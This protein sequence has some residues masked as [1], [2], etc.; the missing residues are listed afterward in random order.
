MPREKSMDVRKIVSM[1]DA[2]VERIKRYRF[3]KQINTEAEA[4]RALIEKGLDAEK[5]K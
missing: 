1:T 5:V 2:L 4:I 3:A